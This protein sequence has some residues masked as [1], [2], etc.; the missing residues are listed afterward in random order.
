MN[1]TAPP[2]EPDISTRAALMQLAAGE[3]EADLTILDA[4]LLNVFTGELIDGVTVTVKEEWIAGV[5]KD[6]PA[7]IGPQT[8]VVQGNGRTLIPGLIDGHTHLAWLFHPATFLEGIL[9]SGTTS[10]ITE[11]MEV[12]PVAGLNGVIEFLGSMANQPLKVWGT[13]PAMGSINPLL[14]GIDA[15]DLAV[16][17]AREDIL[18]MGEAYWQFV[19]QSPDKVLEGFQQTRLAGKT[20]EGHSAGARGPKLSAYA[21]AGISSCHEPITAEETLDRIRLGMHV[22]I[23]EGSI[24]R[25]LSAMLPLSQKNIDHRRLVL[26]TD[27]IDAEDL[28]V[29][30]YME[31]VVQK[32][33]DGGFDP[34]C[35]VQMATLNVAEHFHLDGVVGAIAPG[36]QAD[37][38]LIPDLKTIRPEMVISRGQVAVQDGQMLASVRRHSFAPF[39]YQTVDVAGEVTASDFRIT[40]QTGANQADMRVIEMVTDL[41]TREHIIQVAIVGGTVSADPG[42]DLAK[43]AAIDR[44]FNPG[45]RFVGLIKGFGLKHGAIAASAGWDSADIIIIGVDDDD[46]AL[47]VNCIHQLQGGA[48]VCID[49]EIVAEMPLPIFG[50]LSEKAPDDIRNELGGVNQAAAKAGVP[51]PNPLLTLI[52][53]SG[54]AIPFFRICSAGLVNLKDGKL[55][56]LFC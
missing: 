15:H 25:D 35:A 53:L 11:T 45:R 39:C 24:R 54:A 4:Q 34:A 51:F 23:R 16:L 2:F 27:G 22:M 46:M 37:M 40:G 17:L 12:L 48:V 32:A 8:T 38:V 1:W 5:G 7:C 10:L 33:I 9:S 36:R 26:A 3:G 13:A 31:Y 49:G 55:L 21:A 20:L 18:G 28:A 44:Q 30:G 41:V 52:A 50:L 19:L 56:E 29:K 43:V 6:Q 47:A 14:Q 42:Q